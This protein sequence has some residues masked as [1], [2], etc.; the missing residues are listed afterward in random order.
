MPH[1]GQNSNSEVN[2]LQGW[3]ILEEK[4]FGKIS[5]YFHNLSPSGVK[6]TN[7]QDFSQNSFRKWTQVAKIDHFTIK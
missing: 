7:V 3:K 5:K 6:P 2:T 4:S 1:L